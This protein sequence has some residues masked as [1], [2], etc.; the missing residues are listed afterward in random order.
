LRSSGARTLKYAVSTIDGQI[1]EYKTNLA[2]FC[3]NLL[4]ISTI[5]T[6]VKVYRLLDLAEEAR[7]QIA[8]VQRT[9]DASRESPLNYSRPIVWVLSLA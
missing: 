4:E 8:K 9:V 5:Q 1:E 7:E 6:T 2:A 3:K